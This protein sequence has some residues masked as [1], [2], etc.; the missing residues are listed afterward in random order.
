WGSTKNGPD[1]LVAVLTHDKYEPALRAHAALTL[2]A[3][4]LRGGRR[5]GID[6]LLAAYPLLSEPERAALNQRVIP[7]I[8]SELK[9]PVPAPDKDGKRAADPS[10]PFKD[11]A[12][13]LLASERPPLLNDQERS[14]LAAA[15]GDWAFEG[16]SERVDAPAQRIDMLRLLKQLGPESVRN[17]PQL[18]KADA[19]KLARAVQVIAE[20]GS[21]A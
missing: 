18:V 15:L 8:I 11:A 10:I 4:K 5:E 3:M 19:P 12:S 20:V 2:I 6:R 16:F 21:A 7:A 9:R 17:F 1:K 14:Q 13:A